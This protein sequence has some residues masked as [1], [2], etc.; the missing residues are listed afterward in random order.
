MGTPRH[1]L[2]HDSSLSHQS[3]WAQFCPIRRARYLHIHKYCPRLPLGKRG[4]FYTYSGCLR[5]DNGPIKSTIPLSA[6]YQPS[7][8]PGLNPSLLLNKGWFVMVTGAHLFGTWAV[9]LHIISKAV[10]AFSKGQLF[11]ALAVNISVSYTQLRSKIWKKCTE[12]YAGDS[13]SP[14]MKD[15]EIPVEIWEE[16]QSIYMLILDFGLFMIVLSLV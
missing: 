4:E 8:L 14:Q 9:I 5:E 13:T 10:C 6:S 7:P 11:E 1:L 3:S 12:L 2:R 15:K 16:F